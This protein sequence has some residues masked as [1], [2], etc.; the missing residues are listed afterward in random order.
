[1]T[2]T[3]KGSRDPI[4]ALHSDA[5]TYPKGGIAALAQLIG[6]S[7]GVLHNKF[8]DS[9]PNYEITDREAD[10]LAA[11]IREKT[12]SNAYAEAKAETHGGIFVPLPDPGI[13]GDDDIM[14]SLLNVMLGF[15]DMAKDL[16]EARADGVITPDEFASYKLRGTRLIA[17]VHRHIREIETQVREIESSASSPSDVVA[18][19]TR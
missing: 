9:M 1:M 7:A 19:G 18:I 5:K 16:T 13:A 14:Q 12:G 8:A 17:A 15:G 11:A 3:E 6:R 10:A 4:T 2:H